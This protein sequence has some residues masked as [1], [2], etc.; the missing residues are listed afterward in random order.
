[1]SGH[2]KWANIKTR[3]EAMDKKKGKVFSKMAKI[4]EIAARKG[5]D[6]G[7]NPTLRLTIENARSV[8]MPND[9]IERAIKKGTGEDKEG[10]QLEEMTYEAYGPN[11]TPLII[12]VITD[13]KNRTISEIKH[14]L[15]EHGGKLA[16]TGG[17][18]YLFDRTEGEWKPKY[19]IDIT[20]ENLKQQLEK[21]FG[22][23]DDNDD[24]N[25]IYSN[26]N[27]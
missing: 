3:K 27:L 12:E 4:I 21:L 7:M 25:E 15:N 5:G 9:N 16:E 18:R 26:V 22:E 8:N 11:G 1:M 2:S 14:I 13:N 23:L 6:P 19:S 10:G 20:D 24:V 17:V